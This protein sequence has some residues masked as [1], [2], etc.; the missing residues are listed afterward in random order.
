MATNPESESPADDSILELPI[1]VSWLGRFAGP[2]AATIVFWLLPSGE[3]GQAH[4]ARAT[5][6][7][8][9]LM[10][11]WW[12]TWACRIAVASLVPSTL[13]PWAGLYTTDLAPGDPVEHR[14]LHFRGKFVAHETVPDSDKPHWRVKVIGAEE[15]VERVYPAADMR[16]IPDK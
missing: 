5:A 16:K 4:S 2:I 13:F 14:K 10:G 9:T 1:I 6:A 3:G 7:I 15:P 12:M 8:G 11:V